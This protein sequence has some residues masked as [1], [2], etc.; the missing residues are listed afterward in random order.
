MPKISLIGLK[1]VLTEAHL[2]DQHDG[3]PLGGVGNFCN[4][5]SLSTDPIAQMPI[6][7]LLVP[8]SVPAEAHHGD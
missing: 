8:T 4:G 6:N 7:S 2:V 3:V 1:E 5:K